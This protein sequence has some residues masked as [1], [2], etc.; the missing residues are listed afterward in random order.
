MT[1]QPDESQDV[2]AWVQRAE[3]DLL[4]IENNFAAARVP[5][6]TVC[7]HAQQCAEKYLKALLISNGVSAP[8]SHDLRLLI[9]RIPP[10]VPL[11]L[12]LGR[13]LL[14]NRYTIEGRYPGDWEPL[15]RPVGM[16]AVEIARSVREAV[17][18][19]L[20]LK[21]LQGND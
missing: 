12:N 14:L 9:Q 2:L 21:A 11:N 1:G 20:P 8:K 4:N 5:W 16:E 19:L 15:D 17:R 13:V 6:D 3:H 18:A 7:F 10:T